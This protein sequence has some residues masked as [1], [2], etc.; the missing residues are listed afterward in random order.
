MVE[1][2]GMILVH[3]KIEEMRRSMTPILDY[4]AR[5]VPEQPKWMAQQVGL[6]LHA[7]GE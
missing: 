4:D 1:D 2:A 7:V 5:I 6:V 3:L